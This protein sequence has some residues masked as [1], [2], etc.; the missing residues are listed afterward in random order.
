MSP[1]R[2]ERDFDAIVIGSGLT[3]G[4]AAKELTQLGL[5]TLVLEAGRPIDPRKDYVEHKAPYEFMFRGLGDRRHNDPCDNW[6]M[7]IGIGVAGQPSGV[8]V[9][10]DRLATA[11]GTCVE[12]NPPHRRAAGETDSEG[13]NGRGGGRKAGTGC[14]GDKHCFAQ[15]NDNEQRTA[16]GHMAARNIPIAQL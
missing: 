5:R 12:I 11:F 16:L 9:A 1:Q 7:E 8:G 13:S 3:G 10:L 4:L 2:Q 14:A 6:H 15:R